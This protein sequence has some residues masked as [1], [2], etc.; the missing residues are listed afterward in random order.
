MQ[1]QQCVFLKKKIFKIIEN[2]NK[3]LWIIKMSQIKINRIRSHEKFD[4]LDAIFI[5]KPQNILYILG[6][7]IESESFIMIPGEDLKRYINMFNLEPF[8]RKK[9][10]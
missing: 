1:N 9:G 2:Q 10:N 5:V 7:K 3:F 4:G 6:F 8:L